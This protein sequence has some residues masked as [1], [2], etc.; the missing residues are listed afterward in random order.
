MIVDDFANEA[1]FFP[2]EGLIPWPENSA[3]NKVILDRSQERCFVALS[4]WFVVESLGVRLR[5]F[6]CKYNLANAVKDGVTLPSDYFG[7]FEA[8]YLVGED[9]GV[10][11]LIQRGTVT[12][13]ERFEGG[14]FVAADDL[15]REFL[16]S[17]EAERI[18]WKLRDAVWPT[19]GGDLM[20]FADQF[21]VANTKSIKKHFFPN[22]NIY[23]FYA[24][25]KQAEEFKIFTQ[26][27]RYQT[28]ERHYAEEAKRNKPK[29]K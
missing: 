18:K 20:K 21:H 23:L 10:R 17:A 7:F 3:R 13:C 14:D 6:G 24:R 16:L 9:G 26:E 12:F 22:L 8:Y 1:P 4:P 25:S 29:D 19:L 5:L 15:P 28:A 27:A 11:E 2:A